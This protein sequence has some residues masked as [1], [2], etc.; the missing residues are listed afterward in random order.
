MWVVALTILLEYLNF[1]C[2]DCFHSSY[3]NYSPRS[4]MGMTSFFL[5][6]FS[7]NGYVYLGWYLYF[8]PLVHN[9][10]YSF[11]ICFIKIYQYSYL[12]FSLGIKYPCD[13]C[14]KTF[15]SKC[16]LNNHVKAI[17]K[18]MFRFWKRRSTVKLVRLIHS[19]QKNYFVY[20]FH[21][22]CFNMFLRFLM[23]QSVSSQF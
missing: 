14:S 11:L 9:D 2:C 17:H 4:S 19:H 21:L 16:M 22:H 7:W 20:A 8:Q 5:I 12:F 1:N 10:I 18:G 3:H 23:F 15:S 13:Q 6:L